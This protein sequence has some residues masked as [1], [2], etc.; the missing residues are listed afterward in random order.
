VKVAVT[1]VG[2]GELDRL[3]GTSLTS[4]VKRLLDPPGLRQTE[5]GSEG[6]GLPTVDRAV[7]VLH[8]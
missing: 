3:T 2:K 8:L 4:K 7:A 1:P 6:W 5:E